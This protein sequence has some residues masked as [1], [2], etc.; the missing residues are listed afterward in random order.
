MGI[1]TS[2]EGVQ[3]GSL[4]LL[5]LPFERRQKRRVGVFEASMKGECG[6]KCCRRKTVPAKNG[7]GEKLAPAKNFA[8]E[9]RGEKCRR[10]NLQ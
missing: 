10:Q 2:N 9:I 7:A 1:F 5:C 6:E 8:G 4:G 3:R